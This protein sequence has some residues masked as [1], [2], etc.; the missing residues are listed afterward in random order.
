MFDFRQTQNDFFNQH[1]GGMLV[2]YNICSLLFSATK[3]S[4]SGMS[5][6]LVRHEV[7]PVSAL[8]KFGSASRRQTPS[9]DFRSAVTL[10]G[11]SDESAIASLARP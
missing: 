3:K 7:R 6:S 5:A 9:Y 2:T 1:G 10:S 4:L 8:N 11:A